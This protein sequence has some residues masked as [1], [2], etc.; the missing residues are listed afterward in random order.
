MDV[1]LIDSVNEVEQNTDSFMTGYDA[2]GQVK[3]EDMLIV[4]KRRRR[5]ENMYNKNEKDEI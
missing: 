1:S 5:T 4:A 3:S 2:V